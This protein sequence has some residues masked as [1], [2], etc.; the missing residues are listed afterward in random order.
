MNWAVESGRPGPMGAHHDG[1]GVRFTVFSAHA[2][3][4]EVCV[5]DSAG[6]QHLASFALPGRSGD[7]FHGFLRG[8]GPGLVYGLRAHGPWDLAA[9]HRF[10]P[11]RLLLDPAAREIVDRSNAAA[12]FKAR[13]IADRYD[14]QGDQPPRHA[15]DDTILYEL[16]VAGFT[17]LHPLVPASVRGSYRGLAHPQA[18]DHLKSLGVTAVSLLPVQQHLDE[19]RLVERGLVNYWGYNTLGFFCPEPRLASAAARSMADHGRA[20]RDEFRDMVRALHAAGIE[21]ILDIVFNHSCESDEH[22]PTLCW[23]GLD[24][25][26]WYRLPID[27]RGRYVNHTGCGN[28]L[29]L[30]HPR[31]VQFVIETLRYWVLEM[32]VDGFRFDLA[33][34]LGRG[35]HG[36]DR[37]ALFFEAIASDP[38]LGDIKCIAEP[39]DVGPG[40]YQLGN[41]PAGWLEWNDRFRDA[42]RRYW[43]TGDADR[44]EFARRLCGSADVFESSGRA[45]AASVNFVTA[46]DGFT[47]RDLVSYAQR[48]NEANGEE[49]RDGHGENFGSNL[50]FEGDTDDP[51]ISARRRRL[52]RAL[53]ATVILAQGTP[54]L[55]AGSE[56]GHTQQGNNNAYCQD[57]DIS[58]L[59]WLQVDTDLLSFCREALRLRGSL[60]PLAKDWYAAGPQGRLRWFAIDGTALDSA[61]WH[62]RTMRAF[63]VLI[64]EK[65]AMLFNPDSVLREFALP[66]GR[67]RVLLDTAQS[68]VAAGDPLAA[69]LRLLQRE[70]V[71]HESDQ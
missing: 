43:I 55:C 23:R 47:L 21:V 9:G 61:A 57:N 10:E 22:G 4:I 39:W 65:L 20:I 26:S 24:N 7:L 64:D 15:V 12:D 62:D 5:F 63:F 44:G 36:F 14:W 18:I 3:S 56:L 51:A 30:Q 29:N 67:W 11:G 42:V 2:T 27:D 46:H 45:P 50:G 6:A 60:R 35:D 66:A 38:V 8:A 37:H 49:N 40:G 53:L 69:G 59:N 34:V 1:D 16:H 28:T 33:S 13:V 19:R 48:H 70:S 41:F 52:Q 25:A 58:W 68:S 17:R 71:R 31:V 54:M 32:H